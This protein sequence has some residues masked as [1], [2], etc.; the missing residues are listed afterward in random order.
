MQVTQFQREACGHGAS[1]D[2]KLSATVVGNLLTN[3]WSERGMPGMW[4]LCFSVQLENGGRVFFDELGPPGPSTLC[5]DNG[6]AVFAPPA[7]VQHHVGSDA[8]SRSGTC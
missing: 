4:S 8:F 1:E 2:P 3:P 5:T 7:Y 6:H